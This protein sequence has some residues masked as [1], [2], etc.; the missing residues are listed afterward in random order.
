MENPL[1][2]KKVKVLTSKQ[3][4]PE[5]SCVIHLEICRCKSKVVVAETS[6]RKHYNLTSDRSQRRLINSGFGVS[7]MVCAPKSD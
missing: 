6:G 5:S 7:I 1:V 4:A 2:G 3:N